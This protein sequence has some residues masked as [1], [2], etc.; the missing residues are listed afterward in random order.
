MKQLVH[1]GNN[2][3]LRHYTYKLFFVFQSFILQYFCVITPVIKSK[4]FFFLSLIAYGIFCS[5]SGTV[6]AF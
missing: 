1:M 2:Y 5:S 6:A 4:P 3:N